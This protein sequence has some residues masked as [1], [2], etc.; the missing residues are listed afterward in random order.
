[1][2]HNNDN[3][4]SLGQLIK[5]LRIMKDMTQEE[6]ANDIGYS[7]RQIGRIES[8]ELEISR[9]LTTHLSKYFNIDL[10]EYIAVSRQFARYDSYEEYINFRKALQETDLKSIRKYR[11]R[12]IDNDEYKDGEKLQIIKYAECK[13]LAYESK[14]YIESNKKCFDALSVLGCSDYVKALR[15]NILNE[16]S[17]ATLFLLQ[18]NYDQL[19]E[20]DILNE[21]SIELV[22]HFENFVFKNPIPVKRDMYNLKKYYITALNNLAHTYLR[23]GKYTEALEYVNKSMDKSNDFGISIM[24]YATTHIKFEIYYLM[25]DIENSKEAYEIYVNTCKLTNHEDFRVAFHYIIE[26][27]YPKLLK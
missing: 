13:L 24:L 26:E 27:N 9:E 8:G 15:E 3:V 10:E 17:Y 14:D 7:R 5:K 11:D 4:I 18:Y 23:L 12:L 16:M 1:M 20:I 21:L 2:S 25:G 22:T 6:L 19:G